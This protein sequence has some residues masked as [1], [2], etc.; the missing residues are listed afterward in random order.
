M[1]KNIRF[2]WHKILL[3]AVLLLLP[4]VHV[5]ADESQ[6]LLLVTVSNDQ[7]ENI[8]LNL[9]DPAADVSTPLLTDYNIY[10]HA[11][12]S[13]DGLLAFSTPFEGQLTVQIQDTKHLDQLGR[14]IPKLGEADE[15]P[16]A[17]SIDGHK[18]AYESA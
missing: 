4:L 11:M 6:D 14:M 9:Y 12:L 10:S 8:A 17:W 1:H 18:L 5:G 2:Q 13:T 15:F 3:I 16:L 7:G